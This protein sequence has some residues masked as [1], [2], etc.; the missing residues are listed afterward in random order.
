MGSAAGL[1]AGLVLAAA[2]APPLGVPFVA[3]K[4][5]TCGPASLAMVLAF[6]GQPDLHDDLAAELEAVELRGVAGSRLRASAESRG[7]RAWAFRGDP[8]HLRRMIAQGRPVIVAWDRGKKRMHNVVVVGADD[9]GFVVH[10]PAVGAS[11][12]VD[13]D[14]FE[15]RWTPTDHW[16][17]LVVPR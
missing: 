5:D 9:H 1:V 12:H 17:L 16:S 15:R 11:R 6:W 3:Q 13:H 10:D 8:A 14:L 4:K 2:L 7:F